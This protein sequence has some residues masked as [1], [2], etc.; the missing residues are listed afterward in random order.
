MRCSKAD[1]QARPRPGIQGE[2]TYAVFGNRCPPGECAV[3]I[4]ASVRRAIRAGV[5][6]PPERAVRAL[7]EQ[8]NAMLL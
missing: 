3:L 6:Q 7:V 5:K 2:A 1:G 4:Q 8:W